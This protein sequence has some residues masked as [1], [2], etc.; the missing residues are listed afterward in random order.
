MYPG[1]PRYVDPHG[2]TAQWTADGHLTRTGDIGTLTTAPRERVGLGL[3]LSLGGIVIGCVVTWLLWKA[4]YIASITSFLIALSSVFLYTKGAGAPPRRGLVPLVLVIL[5]GVV[6]SFY[7][8]YIS[9]LGLAYDTLAG[10]GAPEKGEFIRANLFNTEAI[11][12]YGSDLVMFLLFAVLGV[13]G[14][15]RRLLSTV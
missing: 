9:D 7:T 1:H 10:S 4:G 12:A 13:V 6:A 14:I 2:Q 5:V 3:T 8:M 15:V 11:S